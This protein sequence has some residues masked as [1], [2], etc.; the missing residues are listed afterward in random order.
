MGNSLRSEKKK[1]WR[2]D[3][4]DGHFGVDSSVIPSSLFI[5]F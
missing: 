2:N 3:G 1:A 4:A 5:A